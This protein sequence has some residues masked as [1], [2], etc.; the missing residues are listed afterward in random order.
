[1]TDFDLFRGLVSEAAV[2][3]GMRSESVRTVN[4]S[5]VLRH[6]HSRGPATRSQL[7]EQ[8]GLTRSSVAALVG[9]LER[10]G[11]ISEDAAQPD[12]RPGR[13][14]PR[15]K[16]NTDVAV[17]AL[18]I[19]VDSLAI[20]IVGLGGT[21]TDQRRVER[22]RSRA[23]PEDVVA[24]LDELIVEVVDQL[25][26]KSSPIQLIGIGVAV[27]GLIR[28]DTREV[29]FAPNLGWT[30]VP[31]GDMISESSGLDIPLFVGNDGDLGVVAELRRGRAMGAENVLFLNG[32]VG[33]GGGIVSDG[34]L[35]VG[36]DGSA[37]EIG[38]IPVNPQGRDCACGARGCWETEIGERAMLRDAGRSVDGG[39]RAV[40]EVLDAAASGDAT[41]LSALERQGFWVG[42]GLAG[43]VNIFD[44]DMIVLGGVFRRA[45]PFI[46]EPIETELAIRRIVERP[47]P[48]VVVASALG[49]DA[50][51]LGAAEIAFE[52]LLS[53]PLA[54]RADNFGA[55]GSR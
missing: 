26:E 8:I 42:V 29:A 13:P 45:F 39:R 11:L 50:P 10:A 41:A 43:L 37:S 33:I 54:P 27:V 17:L 32:E 35:I 4:L 55:A 28:R 23:T 9:D 25:A 30:D 34:R 1:M 44:P 24:D 21:V 36:R 7:V 19:A 22:H 46:I 20:G 2:G 48:A 14:S 18:E 38:H 53:N 5:T 16:L 49:F 3:S 31:L 52:P 12:G 40:E 15:I 6:L 47:E 51:L